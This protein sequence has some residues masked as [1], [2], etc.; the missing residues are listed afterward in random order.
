MPDFQIPSFAVLIPLLIWVGNAMLTGRRQKNERKREVFSSAYA[1]IA[2]YKEFPYLVRRRSSNSVEERQRI[3]EELRECQKSLAYYTAWIATESHIVSHA[4]GR[5]VE[6]LCAVAGG[7]IHEAWLRLPID[8]DENMN[9]TDIE[10]GALT[11][12]EKAFTQ[13]ITDDLSLWPNWALR[14]L[15][16]R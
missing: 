9:V 13:A 14:F 8:S 3:S 6:E 15:R 12:F 1:A 11:P 4:Y 16:K 7:Y 10:L 2:A 5:L